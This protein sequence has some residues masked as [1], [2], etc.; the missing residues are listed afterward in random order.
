MKCLSIRQPYAELILQHRK[1]I[2]LRTWNTKFRGAFLIHASG[3]VE[4]D[5]CR[6]FGLDPRLMRRMA[7]VGY[8]VLAEV[9]RYP[10]RESL[11]RDSAKHL[12]SGKYLNDTYGFILDDARRIEPFCMPGKLGFFDV[13]LPPGMA[14]ALSRPSRRSS[15]ETAHL[16]DPLLL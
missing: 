5:A 10:D 14:A 8:A 4:R 16:A 2:E 12:A 15:P 13:Q 7:V 9:V 11:M 1:T 3:N 6:G